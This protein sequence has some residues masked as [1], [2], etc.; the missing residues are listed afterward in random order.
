MN[1]V[2]LVLLAGI[3]MLVFFWLRSMPAKRR[4]RVFISLIL[5]IAV[6]F[7]VLMA[8]T[9][10]LHWIAAVVAA[11][12]PFA[13]NFLPVVIRFLPFINHWWKRRQQT[14]QQQMRGNRSTVKTQVLE[15]YLDHDSGVM[16]GSII[17]GPLQG[18]D[19]SQLSEQ[20]YLSLLNY[21]RQHD[22]EGARVLEAYLDKR[23]GDSW[24]QDDQSTA[25]TVPN[26]E[27]TKAE[28]YQLLGLTPGCSE[29]EIITAHRRLMQKVHPD[30][31]GNDYLAAKLNQA[32]DCLLKD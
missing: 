26:G 9:G 28:A 13:R 2:S 1:P 7:I 16:Y 6:L 27:M 24:R 11:A 32:K 17:S 4:T 21:C 5:L 12:L 19:I 29:E 18:R 22:S 23:F 14:K 8:I 10:R 31:G 20:E 3:A 30:R 15:M 25:P